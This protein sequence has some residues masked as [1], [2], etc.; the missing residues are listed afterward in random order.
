VWGQR[1]GDGSGGMERGERVRDGRG[2]EMITGDSFEA[3]RTLRG[4]CAGELGEYFV[5]LRLL[6]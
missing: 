4:G 3:E 5:G 6:V 1:G 2:G